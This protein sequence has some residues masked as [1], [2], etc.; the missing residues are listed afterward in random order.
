MTFVV[1][2]DA[3]VNAQAPS[4]GRQQVCREIEA[5]LGILL[6]F[7][8]PLPDN[9]LRVGWETLKAVQ[10]APRAIPNKYAKSTAGGSACINGYQSDYDQFCKDVDQIRAHVRAQ[11]GS[12]QTNC[13]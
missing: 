2:F 1:L 12:A 13:K 11:S 3:R 7:M 5:P 6:S 4:A 8:K 10:M 9:S